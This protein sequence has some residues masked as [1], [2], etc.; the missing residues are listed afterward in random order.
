MI[1][2]C[3][4]LTYVGLAAQSKQYADTVILKDGTVLN[5]VK[6]DEAL[7]ITTAD[8]KTVTYNKNEV[9]VEESYVVTNSEEKETVYKKDEVS[10]VKKGEVAKKAEPIPDNWS[11]NEGYMN[12]EDAKEKCTSLKM[13]LPSIEELKAAQDAK[14]TESWKKQGYL[15]WSSSVDSSGNPYLLYAYA[16]EVYSLNHFASSYVRCIQ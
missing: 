14:K 12:W 8:G 6:A 1:V 9:T 7:V 5:N 3:F 13:R 2:V 15:Y 10:E 4:V 16:G 11:G